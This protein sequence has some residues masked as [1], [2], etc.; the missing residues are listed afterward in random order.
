MDQ[1]NRP[2]AENNARQ[3]KI[4]P[5]E[6]RDT[7]SWFMSPPHN[8][9]KL[10]GLDSTCLALCYNLQCGDIGLVYPAMSMDVIGPSLLS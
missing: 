5:D 7:S 10:Q 3:G 1:S 8:P 2:S 4:M 6:N 9:T